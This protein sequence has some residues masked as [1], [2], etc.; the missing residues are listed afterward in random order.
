MKKLLSIIGAAL[1]L[2]VI[3]AFAGCSDNAKSDSVGE[4]KAA[5]VGEWECYSI[6]EFCGEESYTYDA[7]EAG[8]I[9][10]LTVNEDGTFKAAGT[11]EN[12][13]YNIVSG[14]W[15]Q[16]GE[17]VKVSNVI[18]GDE[19]SNSD[20]SLLTFIFTDNDRVTLKINVEISNEEIP[21]GSSYHLK[22]R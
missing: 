5:F 8:I 11:Y 19:I 17:T 4:A 3:V 20:D 21:E 16:D 22:K 12:E 9:C 2:A 15:T 7:S 18:F 1:S 13:N 6:T 14:N 10:I